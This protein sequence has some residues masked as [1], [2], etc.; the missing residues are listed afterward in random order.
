MHVRCE[1]CKLCNF[2]SFSKRN[3]DCSWYEHCNWRELEIVHAGYKSRVVHAHH[4]ASD[5]LYALGM[6]VHAGTPSKEAAA[7]AMPEE[8]GAKLDAKRAMP[9]AQPRRHILLVSK[10][11]I[12]MSVALGAEA[13]G[14]AAQVLEARGKEPGFVP[15]SLARVDA[16]GVLPLGP[17]A[18]ATVALE[19]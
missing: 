7:S 17:F 8:L 16:E 12:P 4:P 9:T 18:V 10:L 2:V 1:K 13:A 3:Q 5:D 11:D 19:G 6:R 15:P 14:A